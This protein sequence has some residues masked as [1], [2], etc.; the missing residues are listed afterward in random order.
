MS[1]S[2]DGEG[3]FTLTW[4]YRNCGDYNQDGIVDIKDITPLAVHF[5]E[6]IDP[7][8]GLWEHPVCEVIDG[9][10]DGAITILDITPLAANFFV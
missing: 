1:Y 2:V 6:F 4:S 10:A 8:S 9:N 3:V 7:D 5:G